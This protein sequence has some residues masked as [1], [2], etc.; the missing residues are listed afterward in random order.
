MGRHWGKVQGR[1]G[2]ATPTGVVVSTWGL[3]WNVRDPATIE[4]R[5]DDVL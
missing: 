5:A 1:A 2:A 3:G 4:R